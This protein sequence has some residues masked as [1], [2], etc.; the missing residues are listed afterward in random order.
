MKK[1]SPLFYAC[2]ALS[3]PGVCHAGKGILETRPGFRPTLVISDILTDTVLRSVERELDPAN[4]GD[5]YEDRNSNGMFD[6][7][8]ELGTDFDGDGQ[9]D[10][11]VYLTRVTY[12]R[13]PVQRLTAKI[14][15]SLR[16]S[17]GTNFDFS[18]VTV[19]TPVSIEIGDYSFS[20]RLGEEQGR[21]V[22]RKAGVLNGVPYA[23][24][25]AKPLGNSAVYILG[26]HVRRL[27][28]DGTPLLDPVGTPLTRFREDGRIR[29]DWNPRLGLVQ[30]T[31]QL[32]LMDDGS[33][34]ATP[35][36][37]ATRLPDS[38]VSGKQTFNHQPIP[39]RVRFGMATG[40]RLVYGKGIRQAGAHRL[41]PAETPLRSIVVLGAA[42]HLAPRLSRMDVPSQSSDGRASFSGTLSDRP[43]PTFPGLFEIPA[44]DLVGPTL[45]VYVN[46][47]GFTDGNGAE[48]GGF[49]VETSLYL[50][51]QCEFGGAAQLAEP[52]NTLRLVA[53]D[54][55]GN[56]SGR[57]FRVRA[58]SS[59]SGS[60]SLTKT[61]PG[62]F[63]I[64]PGS[65]GVV[66]NPGSGSPGTL[67]PQGQFI[68]GGSGTVPVGT[69][70]NN[71]GFLNPS[72]PAGVQTQNPFLPRGSG[73]SAGSNG[74]GLN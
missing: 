3:L 42:D 61:G 74:S 57:I 45:E 65:G 36:F 41:L 55:D 14:V 44:E 20:G 12:T 4:P 43:A 62:S 69:G 16:D 21:G 39:V 71:S 28:K 26:S 8:D 7:G 70:T 64:G 11:P 73:T 27:A 23:E 25:D 33:F 29:V 2:A 24:G 9:Y 15:A 35:S 51:G 40:E 1:I 38:T 47:T 67:P 18:S 58:E 17:E 72:G 37:L 59:S 60:A 6:A 66:A 48:V 22:W 34:G 32:R 31:V 52:V 46:G 10:D 5:S 30:F 19:D 68:L 54:A 50:N 56:E 63:L 49:P 13:A 53:R